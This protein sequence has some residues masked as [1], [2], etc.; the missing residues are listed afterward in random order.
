MTCHHRRV[1]LVGKDVSFPPELP[2]AIP[3][4]EGGVAAS[5]LVVVLRLRRV[6]HVGGPLEGW[7]WTADAEVLPQPDHSVARAARKVLEAVAPIKPKSP[8]LRYAL[9]ELRAVL[10]FHDALVK[11]ADQ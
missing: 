2:C 1:L 7:L 5:S 3:G 8:V 11:K 10:T 9:N 4:C 6:R